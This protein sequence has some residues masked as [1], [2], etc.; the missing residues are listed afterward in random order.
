MRPPHQ[1]S[2]ATTPALRG[3]TRSSQPPQMAA[4]VPSSTKNSVYIQP[5]SNWVQSQLVVKSA[6]PVMIS[7]PPKVVA[8]P[9]QTRS[10]EH[11]SALQSLM[12]ISY[13]VFRLK[14]KIYYIKS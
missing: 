1:Q 13:A 6:C 3:P 9:G 2:A 4:E 14:K 12:R 7:L 11:T 5:R 10:E 8:S